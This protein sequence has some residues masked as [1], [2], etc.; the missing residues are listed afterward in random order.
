MSLIDTSLII[1]GLTVVFL[2][3]GTAIIS[4]LMNKL[5][6]ANIYHKLKSHYNKHCP[7]FAE[8]PPSYE[9][10][11]KINKAYGN[12]RINA[13]ISEY[14]LFAIMIVFTF[15]MV[16]SY[17]LSN[18]L[19][20]SWLEVK[21]GVIINPVV[22]KEIFNLIMYTPPLEGILF[23]IIAPQLILNPY[24]NYLLMR[25]LFV[26]K[27]IPPLRGDVNLSSLTDYLSIDVVWRN[28]F[29]GSSCIVLFYFSAKILFV[30]FLGAMF[31]SKYSIYV[32]GTCL[33]FSITFLLACR[34][35]SL[36]EMF[37]NVKHQ[38]R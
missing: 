13:I 6:F 17:L 18:D 8:P 12:G 16:I 27:I 30:I 36:S 7:I 19:L 21:M 26:R 25:L 24:L 15:F 1:I 23:F 5:P 9:K 31:V 14:F 35:I 32:A 3:V 38:N 11:Y 33:A 34:V 2:A 28:F 29:Y 4:K 22:S 37:S 10:N 20:G